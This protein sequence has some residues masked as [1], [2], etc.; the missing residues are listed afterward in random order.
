MP[1]FTQADHEMAGTSSPAAQLTRDKF[2]ELH[3]ALYRRIRENNYDLHL[4]WD[5]AQIISSRSVAAH[6]SIRGL[7]GLYLRSQD[8][9]RQV[10]RLMGRD[11]A[12]V[13]AA[14]HPVIELRL[15]PQH[16]AVDLVVSPDAWWDQQNLIGKLSIDRHISTLRR[17]IE[18]I[19]GDYSF[20]FWGGIE[21]SEMHVNSGHLLRGTILNEWMSTFA[22]GQDW[23]RVGVW[24]EPEAETLNTESILSELH[25]RVIG[26]Y[27]CYAFLLWTSNN[28]YHSFYNAIHQADLNDRST[29][30]YV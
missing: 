19:G 20:G 2:T 9:A 4:H 3:R 22:D 15:T 8:H 25:Q 18:I 7:T 11:G 14:R 28:N 1:Y 12:Q 26:L 27:K 17:V 5:R 6:G 13:E 30:A 10:E 24:Y 21:L 29:G 16:L 23:F